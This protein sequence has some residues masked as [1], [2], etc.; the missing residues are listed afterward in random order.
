[1]LLPGG[2][3]IELCSL[4]ERDF[5]KVLRIVG[6]GV[7]Y[8]PLLSPVGYVCEPLPARR[9]LVR[10]SGFRVGNCGVASARV[11]DGSEVGLVG[12]ATSKRSRAK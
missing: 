7:F 8:G 11:C 10:G 6:L 12:S 4:C 1:M 9:P 2:E 3:Q 5:Y